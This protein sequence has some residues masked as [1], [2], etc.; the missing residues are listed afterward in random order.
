MKSPDQWLAFLRIVVGVCFLRGGLQKVQWVFLGNI[1][2]LPW[3]SQRWIHF[4][5]RRVA[6]FASHN[7]ISWYREFLT[8][9][10]I[11]HR[12]TFAALVAWGELGAGLG[13]I[14]GLFTR[15]SS[16]VAFFL[17]LNFLLA[18]FW[19]GPCELWFHTLLLSL[20]AAFLFSGAGHTWGVDGWLANRLPK[21]SLSRRSSSTTRKV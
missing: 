12:E 15:F 13:L 20:A 3:V 2:P 17:G 21:I 7:P 6:E 18:T 10:V 14:L 16:A 8:G 19:L 11:P 5:P 9:F 4:M 1:F